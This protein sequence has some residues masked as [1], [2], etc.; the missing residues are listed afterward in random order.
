MKGLDTGALAGVLQG[1]AF[2]KELM[3]DLR[4]REVATTELTMMELLLMANRGP[5]RGR[6][7]HRAAVER[8]R[9]KISV[10]P[11]DARAVAEAAHR[12]RGN[13]RGPELLRL[14]EW[15]ALEAYG[16]DQLFA[17]SD[18]VPRGAWRFKVTRVGT[19]RR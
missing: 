12:G 6:A 8:L 14:A 2:A 9:R 13:V 18:V 11:I 1:E 7:A 17:R 15:G 5:S 19:K 4:G 3:R 10:L 16:C